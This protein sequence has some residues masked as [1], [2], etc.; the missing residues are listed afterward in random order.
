MLYLSSV[1]KSTRRRPLSPP[2]RIWRPTSTVPTVTG[3]LFPLDVFHETTCVSLWELGCILERRGNKEKER[4]EEVCCAVWILR[5]FQQPRHILVLSLSNIC[6]GD[7]R[8]VTQLVLSSRGQCSDS[9]ER[10]NSR[11]IGNFTATA[12]RRCI[13]V[14]HHRTRLLARFFL[15][16][17]AGLKDGCDR[18]D[19]PVYLGQR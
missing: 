13:A 11:F 7:A 19:F 16:V 6:L 14:S 5:V 12:F 4:K 2:Q 18:E 8:C 3:M 1:I 9:P 17:P 10:L 15:C